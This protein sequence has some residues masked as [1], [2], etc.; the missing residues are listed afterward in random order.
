M[1]FYQEYEIY[2]KQCSQIDTLEK[3]APTLGVILVIDR[4]K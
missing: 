4:S 3:D 1:N 2:S